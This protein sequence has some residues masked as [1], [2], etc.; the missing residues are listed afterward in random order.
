M[1]NA[2]TK[3]N[4]AYFNGCLVVAAVIGLGA[5]SWAVFL[6]A[7]AVAVAYGVHAGDIRPK[8]VRR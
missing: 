6:A 1:G 4:V 7:L 2:R 3:L 8:P 5:R